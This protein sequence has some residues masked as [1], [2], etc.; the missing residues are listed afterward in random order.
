MKKLTAVYKLETKKLELGKFVK[1]LIIEELANK[2]GKEA[3][4]E[5]LI[6][7]GEKRL[8][9][10]DPVEIDETVFTAEAMFLSSEEVED[11]KKVLKNIKFFL[12]DSKADLYH[13][14][15]SLITGKS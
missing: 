7:V 12:P 13:E 11:L 8:A 10:I 14:A 4:K 9:Q 1:E 15:V 2:I 3:L 6:T 5:G